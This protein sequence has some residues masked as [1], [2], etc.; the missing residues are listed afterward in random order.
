MI[1][2]PAKRIEMP[3][4]KWLQLIVTIEAITEII[5]SIKHTEMYDDVFIGNKNKDYV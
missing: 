5:Q 2:C 4:V 1:L 3:L